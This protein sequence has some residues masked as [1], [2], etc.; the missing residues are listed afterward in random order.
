MDIILDT[1]KRSKNFFFHKVGTF[2]KSNRKI[3]E[4][5]KTD[6][7]SHKYMTSNT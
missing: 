4:R 3:V 6:T 7:A 5:G 2:Q 1:N